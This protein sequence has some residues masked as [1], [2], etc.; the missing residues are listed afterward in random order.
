MVWNYVFK[1]GGDDD[2]IL[3]IST[4]RKLIKEERQ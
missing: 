3:R 1:P 4:D 2:I